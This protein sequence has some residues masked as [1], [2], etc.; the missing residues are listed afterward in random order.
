MGELIDMEEWR[1]RHRRKPRK[2]GAPITDISPELPEVPICP[3]L[4]GGHFDLMQRR[5]TVRAPEDLKE[6]AAALELAAS[7]LDEVHDH[8]A[9]LL[10]KAGLKV[11]I[12]GDPHTGE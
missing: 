7:V 3:P 12:E 6:V 4:V 9:K 5:V 11:V 1:S 2:R 8:A 10:A